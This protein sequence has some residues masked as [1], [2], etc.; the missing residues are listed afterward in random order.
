MREHVESIEDL[1]AFKWRISLRV[2][3]ERATDQPSS[4]DKCGGEAA[5]WPKTRACKA[6]EA[7]F[8]L[9]RHLAKDDWVWKNED[10]WRANQESTRARQWK[11]GSRSEKRGFLHAKNEQCCNAKWHP[12]RIKK[13]VG[14][15]SHHDNVLLLNL[16]ICEGAIEYKRHCSCKQ[17][18]TQ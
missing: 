10:L 12:C 6:K 16:V 2:E 3:E 15:F 11:T 17:S 5:L 18:H 7:G 14:V 9:L 13:K 8:V 4:F 1:R